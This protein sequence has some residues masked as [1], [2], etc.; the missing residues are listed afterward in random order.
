M[1]RPLAALA[2]ACGA[3]LL[4]A[5]AM[6]STRNASASKRVTETQREYLEC[7]GEC[8]QVAPK[9]I[10]QEACAAIVRIDPRQLSS[11]NAV[12]CSANFAHQGRPAANQL[13]HSQP[14]ST[15]WPRHCICPAQIAL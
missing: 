5:C 7:V 2:A 6:W 4:A 11:V 13:W 12:V 10:C 14:H 9:P 3:A 8:R 1:N 15:A